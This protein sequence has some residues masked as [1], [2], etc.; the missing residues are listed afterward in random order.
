MAVQEPDLRSQL[1]PRKHG[2]RQVDQPFLE[3]QGPGLQLVVA[4]ESVCARGRDHGPE[5][6]DAAGQVLLA[7]QSLA[8]WLDVCARK[9]NLGAGAGRGLAA[10]GEQSVLVQNQCGG[11][12]ETLGRRPAG[13][14]PQYLVESKRYKP[15]QVRIRPRIQHFT[16]SH[17]HLV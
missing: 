7:R 14:D 5:L 8:Y 2:V 11:L 6:A 3:D 12:V 15:H 10:G 1:G 16:Y 17:I 4:L 13:A 9:R